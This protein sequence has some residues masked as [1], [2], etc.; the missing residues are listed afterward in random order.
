MNG[1]AE[2]PVALVT[3]ASAGIGE[4]IA[5]RLAR[6]GFDLL[7]VARREEPLAALA[8]ALDGQARVET[9]ALDVSDKQ[10]GERAVEAAME[11]F[12]RL[13]ALVNNAGSGKFAQLRR[14]DEDMLDELIDLTLKAPFRF[15]KAAAK[16][17]GSGSSITYIGSTFGMIGGLNGGMYSAVKSGLVGLTRSAAI[18]LGPQGIRCNLVA[19]SVVR[20]AMIEEYW[21]SEPFRRVNQ[22]FT[23]FDRMGTP[24]DIANAVHFLASAEGSFINGQSLAV[25]GGWSTTKYLS[26]EAVLAKRVPND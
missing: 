8:S 13:D 2:K 4:A 18:E 12:G 14:T 7:A 9:L 17:M 25:D 10:A 21:N 23:P 26:K 19:P 3:G 22:E 1:Q 6:G 15:T 5:H 11:R 24:E 16:V 20:T